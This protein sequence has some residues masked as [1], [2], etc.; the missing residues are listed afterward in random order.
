MGPADLESLS[1]LCTPWCIRVA[2]TL[3]IAEH[4]SAGI[5]QIDDLA[6]AAACE[7]WVLHRLLEHLVSKGVFSEPARGRFA[8]NDA[9]T[10]LLDDSVRIGLDLNGIGSRLAHVWSTLLR[11]VQTGQ[12]AYRD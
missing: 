5:T 6:A 9:A 3:R 11:F 8:L 4:I 7:A 2:V 1:D 12:P 10:A